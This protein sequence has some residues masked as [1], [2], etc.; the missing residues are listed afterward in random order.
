M[1]PLLAIQALGCREHC[2]LCG[3]AAL[4]DRIHVYHLFVRADAQVQGIGRALWQHARLRSN[5]ST[6]TVN[7]SLNAVPV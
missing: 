7:A 3:V 4:R 1:D 5:H 2:G 6:F